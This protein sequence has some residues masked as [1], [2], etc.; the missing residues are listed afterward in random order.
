[1]DPWTPLFKVA[2]ACKII[3]LKNYAYSEIS[4]VTSTFFFLFDYK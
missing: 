2:V 3:I 4:T 1:M